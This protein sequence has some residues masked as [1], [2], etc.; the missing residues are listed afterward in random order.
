MG[1]N[2]WVDYPTETGWWWCK[3]KNHLPEMC[4]IVVKKTSGDDIV[5]AIYPERECYLYL[6]TVKPKIVWQK[7]KR[8]VT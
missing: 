3:K 1:S 4:R 5:L 2:R 8:Y 6:D 7:V